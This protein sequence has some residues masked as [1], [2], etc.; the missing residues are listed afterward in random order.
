MC[1][2][3]AG[4]APTED[5]RFIWT[6]ELKI[7]G[8]NGWMREDLITLIE[9]IQAGRLKP[10]AIAAEKR[11][12]RFPEVPTTAE[13]VA[14]IVSRTASMESRNFCSIRRSRPVPPASSR[15]YDAASV[16]HPSAYVPPTDRH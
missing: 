15:E 10:L 16:P 11:S 2:A 8:S 13:Q 1:G 7:L 6:F 5:I 12:T 14:A 4:Y 9:L 3:T